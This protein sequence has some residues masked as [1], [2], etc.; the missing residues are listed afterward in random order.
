MAFVDEQAADA[1]GAAVKILVAAPSCEV[2]IPVVQLQR[3]VSCCV[4]KIPTNDYAF[5]LCVG[6]DGGDVEELASVKLDTRQ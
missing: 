1:S 4:S 2:D 3:H 5:A 6:G